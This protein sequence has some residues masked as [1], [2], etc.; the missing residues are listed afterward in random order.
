VGF[1]LDGYVLRPARI[2]PGNAQST[3]EVTV[4]VDRDHVDPTNFGYDLS[5]SRVVEPA[6][7]MYRA[8]VLNR[9][10]AEQEE[11]LIWPASTSSLSV[12]E[13]TAFTMTGVASAVVV[14]TGTLAVSD[15]SSPDPD[16]TD[17]TDRVYVQDSDGRAIGQVRFLSVTRGDGLGTIYMGPDAT[18]FTPNYPFFSQNP[19]IGEVVFTEAALTAL[20][21]GVSKERGD[22]ITMVTYYLGDSKFWWCRNDPHV[23][24]FGW[25]GGIQKWTPLKGAPPQNLGPLKEDGAYVLSPRLTRFTAGDWLPGWDGATADVYA[26]IRIGLYSNSSS[27][28]PDVVVVTDLVVEAPEDI[29]WAAYVSGTHPDGASAVVGV[30]N[31]VLVFNPDYLALH[32][33]KTVW[34][35]PESFTLAATGLMK[36]LSEFSLTS[37]SGHPI[38]SPIPSPTD[39]PMLRLGYRRYLTPIPYDDD[40]SLPAPDSLTE[41]SF[42]WSRTTGQ[43][44]LCA[45]DVGKAIPTNANYQ[46]SYLK[47]MVYYDGVSMTTQPVPARYPVAVVKENGNLLDG[48]DDDHDVPLTGDLY[49]RRAAPLPFPGTSGIRFI[50]DKTGDIPTLTSTGTAITTRPNGNGLV[51]SAIGKGDNFVFAS[52]FAFQ[53]LDNNEYE[54]DLSSFSFTVPKSKAEIARETAAVQPTGSTTASRME[55]RRRS[56]SGDPLYFSQAEITPSIYRDQASIYSRYGEPYVLTGNEVLRFTIDGDLTGYVWDASADPAV[57]SGGSF[58]AAVIATSL[59]QTIGATR[60]RVVR[61]RVVI[62]AADPTNGS[63]EIGWNLPLP[64]GP[65]IGDLSGHAALGF[66]PG[67]RVVA[68]DAGSS[69]YRWLPDNGSCLGLYRSPQNLGR[70][71]NTPDF[72]AE[73]RFDTQILTDSLAQTPFFYLPDLPLVDIPGFEPD[74]H[75][76]VRIG[77]EIVSLKDYDGVRYEF[78]DNR[79]TWL[80][81]NDTGAE[82][83]LTP[84]DTLQL[85][86]TGVLPQTI[87]SD[88]MASVGDGFGL[89]L[90]QVGIDA[91]TGF[92]Y[93]LTELTEGAEFLVPGGGAPGAAELIE[94]VGGQIGDGTAGVT[95]AASATFA[96]ANVVFVE[97]SASAGDLLYIISGD[98]EGVYT[99]SAVDS[100][101]NTLEVSPSFSFNS[102]GSGA[103]F[104]QWELY[105]GQT[106][107]VYDPA[108]VADVQQVEFNHLPNEPFIIRAL[109]PLGVIGVAATFI[110]FVETAL[111]NG[112]KTHVRL[113]LPATSPERTI[114][115]LTTG[116]EIGVVAAT[117]LSVP[118]TTNAHFL[119]GAFAI[120]VGSATYSV[121][122]GNLVA[123][124]TLAPLPVS[125]DVV[126][127]VSDSTDADFG[128]LQFGEDTLA[129]QAGGLVYFD[130][131]LDGPDDITVDTVQIDPASGQVQ[132][133]QADLTAYA[134]T[135]VYYVE[136][137]ITERSLDVQTSPMGG[138]FFF[139]KP[140]RENQI[141]EVSYF[142]A[143]TEG[144]KKTDSVTGD[145]LPMITE[146][147]ALTVR[148]EEATRVSGLVYSFNPTGRTLS[149][150]IEPFMW[151][152]VELQ[153][154]AGETTAS[155]DYDKSEITFTTEVVES[156]T[157]KINYGV[158]EAFGGETTYN[159]STPP[160]WRPPLLL[161]KEQTALVLG[162][163]RTE[164]VEVGA[165][166]RLGP[167]M[168]YIKAVSYSATSDETTV[169]LWPPQPTEAG[170]RSPGNDAPATISSVPVAITVDPSDPVYPS[171]SHAGFLMEITDAV[172][173]PIQKHAMRVVFEGD[174]RFFL[175][176]EHLLEIGGYPHFIIRS[177]LSEDG[178]Y[179]VVDLTAPVLQ[180][181]DPTGTSVRISARPLYGIEP[182]IFEGL[183]P[184]V[185]TE[186]NSVFLLGSRDAAGT[187]LPGRKLVVGA[188]YL[189]DGVNGTIRFKI[190]QKNGLQ[191][192]ERL[193]FCYTKRVVVQ[194]V[195]QESAI[196][197]PTYKAKYLHTTLPTLENGLLGSV[198]VGKYN[199]R[200]A[201][202]F[203][204]RTLPL[205]SYLTD[206]AE[207]ALKKVSQSSVSGGPMLAFPGSPILHKEGNLGLRSE[208]VDLYDQDRAAR[209]YIEFYNEAIVALEQVLETIDGRL[210]GDRDG[211]FRFFIGHG[212][213][214]YPPGYE[215][216]ITGNLNNRLIWRFIL[217]SWGP[218]L[219]TGYFKQKD[220]VVNPLTLVVDPTGEEPQ[221][222]DGEAANPVFLDFFINRQKYRVKNDMDDILLTGLKRP[223]ML[224]GLFPIPSTRGRYE[225]MWENHDFSRL[226]PER[227]KHFS[228]LF[229]GLESVVDPV[230]GGFSNPGY[231]SFGRKQEVPGP[232]PG[233]TQTTTARTIGRPI[234]QL[235]NP[236]LEELTR[237]T[238]VS[239][240]PRLARARIWE[241]HPKGYSGGS[242]STSGPTLV[243]TPLPF[244]EF[245]IDPTTGVPDAPLLISGGGA[246]ADLVSGDADQSTPGFVSGDRVAFGTPN[247][248]TF[249]LY[250]TADNT[251]V[252]VDEII[253]GFVITLKRASDN[254][255]ITSASRISTSLTGIAGEWEPV[256][257]DTIYVVPPVAFPTEGDIPG[258][259]DSPT[260]EQ[261]GQFSGSIPDY[262]MGFDVKARNKS[263]AIIDLSL[264]DD[265]D[266]FPLPLQS[267]LGQ[268]PPSPLS[269]IEGVAEFINTDEAPLQ[270]PCLKGEAADDSGEITIPYLRSAD[271]ELVVLK[272]VGA[273]AFSVLADAPLPT[274]NIPDFLQVPAIELQV[275]DPSYDFLSVYPDEI[276]GTDG[277]ITEFTATTVDQNPAT[278]YTAQDVRPVETAGT[279]TA[280]SGEGDL[281]R[282]DLLFVQAADQSDMP[283]VGGTGIQTVGDTAGHTGTGTAQSTIEIPRFISPTH[284]GH[285]H[286]YTVNN[287]YGHKGPLNTGVQVTETTLTV[288]V[289]GFQT[290]FSFTGI[291]LNDGNGTTFDEGGVAEILGVA[292][293]S[294]ASNNNAVI[295]NIYDPD[296]N[297]S[298]AAAWLG[299]VVITRA[300]ASPLTN[301]YVDVGGGVIP[302]PYWNTGVPTQVLAVIDTATTGTVVINTTSSVLLQLG[303]DPTAHY[304]YTISLDTY[305]DADTAAATGGAIV[306]PSGDG[307]ATAFIGRDRLTFSEAV[308]MEWALPR[309][310]H[311]GDGVGGDDLGMQLN[312]AVSPM[313]YIA[314]PPSYLSTINSATS[315]NGGTYLTFLERWSGGNEYVGT[316]TPATAPG[317]GDEVGTVRAMSWEGNDNAPLTG[318]A[319]GLIFS[320]A[321][322]SNLRDAA[323]YDIYTARGDFYDS[324]YTV[325]PLGIKPWITNLTTFNGNLARIESGDI[326]VVEGA[327][328][329]LIREETYGA[330]KTGTYLVRHAIPS[331]TTFAGSSGEVYSAYE[332]GVDD[333]EAEVSAGNKG[334]FDLR[335]PE[336]GSLDVTY[337]GS[338]NVTAMTLNLKNVPKALNLD[339][340][341]VFPL[342][343][344]QNI[345]RPF[346]G[347]GRVY[348]IFDAQYATYDSTIVVPAD[349][350]TVVPTSVYSIDFTSYTQVIGET[351][352]TMVL[353]VSAPA[354][355]AED[356]DVALEDF[357]PKIISGTT[358]SGMIRFMVGALQDEVTDYAGFPSNNVVGLDLTS[359]GDDAT[360]GFAYM[361][362]GNRLLRDSASLARPEP[363]LTFSPPAA[364]LPPITDPQPIR[365]GSTFNI[366]P[367]RAF[368]IKFRDPQTSQAFV[369]E[370]KRVLYGRFNTRNLTPT[371]SVHSGVPL[372]VSVGGFADQQWDYIHFTYDPTVPAYPPPTNRLQCLLPGDIWKAADSLGPTAL[373][374]VDGLVL[375]AGVFMEPSFPKPTTD[376]RMLGAP[377]PHV[378][379]ASHPLTGT[380]TD[381]LGTRSASDFSTYTDTWEP[382]SFYVRRIRRFH[383]AQATVTGYLEKLRY[384]YKIR[385]G[386]FDSYAVATRTFTAGIATY[387]AATNL[388]AF[389]VEE[390]NI[391]PGDTLR[392]FDTNGTLMDEAEIQ[393][394]DG[395]TTLILH[396]PGLTADLA[397][398]TSFEV[399]LRQPFVP[400]EQ[401]NE[402]L[403]D[404][405]T[406]EV[407]YS[408]SVTYPEAAVTP[409]DGGFVDGYPVDA[410]P[411][412]LQDPDISPTGT[413]DSWEAVGVQAN[414][415]LIVDPAGPLYDKKIE[416]GT[417]PI[418][419][420]SV[421]GR[422]PEHIVYPQAITDDNRGFYK[423]GEL[424]EDYPVIL[425]LSGA[426]IFAGNAQDG[427]DDIVF[428]M[429]GVSGGTPF[430]S[431]Y[432][433][434][435]TVHGS[436][437]TSATDSREGQQGLR[438][439]APPVDDGSG[440]L[441]YRE[442]TTDSPA[443]NLYRSVQPFGYKIIRPSTLFS[444][445]ATDT[446]LFM[447]ERLLSWME[448]IDGIYDKSGSYY[449]FQQEDQIDDLG[450]SLLPSSGLGLLTNRV[451]TSFRGL[452][453]YSPYANTDDCLSV[454]GRR[455]WILDFTLDS[456][457]PPAPATFAYTAFSTGTFGQ[458]PVLIGYINDILDNNDKLRELRYSWIAFRADRQDGSIVV[459]RRAK[460]RLPRNL[461]KQLELIEQ[462]KS[463]GS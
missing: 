209:A 126:N 198:L 71:N 433:V 269:A 94:V 374:T 75:F 183:F 448:E 42:A 335:F 122:N 146:F 340:P 226:Y 304:D 420:Q 416:M 162:G 105:T 314:G 27:D 458:R 92:P 391:N 300:S 207:V 38:L 217:D 254:A 419:D 415:Y 463:L 22:A 10:V 142:Q 298:G 59:N 6:A 316:F 243:A 52:S 267:W 394:V 344:S 138:A 50:P 36:E 284:R 145:P 410:T 49:V 407:V 402:Q 404:L 129:A 216:E 64:G 295:I 265:K 220:P 139:M 208:V 180:N 246:F 256:Q 125:G 303:L 359:A 66:L 152:G 375:L 382:V 18:T 320:S 60:V 355:D 15:P 275:I 388:G 158:L 46:L 273:S 358:I 392:V 231:Y 206:V 263:G 13:D 83:I 453:E 172:F 185:S 118:G 81:S 100:T 47:T 417:R 423:V 19:S 317:A 128:A 62:E 379:T 176:A 291:T 40:N 278:L 173:L 25:D 156:D 67:W 268:N 178:R 28:I 151:V 264:P 262:R 26:L 349:R 301:L 387:G 427:S 41:G 347:T 383:D 431:E 328:E 357:A 230:S 372:L 169:T 12:V 174:L 53:K 103:A 307:S 131:V 426:C 144:T 445:E 222:V 33:G 4:G 24:R 450:N 421:D 385:R 190:P 271:S 114:Q 362:I 313:G 266:D 422:T 210:I 318:G 34:H 261:S 255:G 205:S 68:P 315:M 248:Q 70:K 233:E 115:Y 11:Y 215:D 299:R 196:I 378:V 120:R 286:W 168:V 289:A 31:G 432:V 441:V 281:R 446:I 396:R 342:P 149:Q 232:N 111:K 437:L 191:P 187:L 429:E 3:G 219:G 106:Q 283:F 20:G 143:A 88:A 333:G 166:L 397:T 373:P 258:S 228:R 77:D 63:V 376:I 413:Y 204:Y 308:A 457:I 302:M 325:T 102:G 414:D 449:I 16:P 363:M 203:Y 167:L 157:V 311:P 287:L 161:E 136:Q 352:A 17:G 444:P 147:L 227:T 159:V 408:R 321:P 181:F 310:T 442:R 368:D 280:E 403:L 393:K 182:A 104:A 73:G 218:D 112:R 135:E 240:Q 164:D 165:V 312:V 82:R 425:P 108:L 253:D 390:V 327:D 272:N 326:V 57:S 9:P 55:I 350:Y 141:V 1:N 43:T 346:A 456:E 121:A 235:S 428:G 35:S 285:L 334:L 439:T 244:S 252:L 44:V 356:V 98:N 113:G 117:A 323:A 371:N 153:N 250:E 331:T 8:A 221:S 249:S 400:H 133:A 54:T 401:S 21:G 443:L 306:S 245:P 411:H 91:T 76:K 160:V 332:S 177:D 51:R 435:P 65:G 339:D 95:T 361:T 237:L 257:G 282:G 434:L 360:F 369:E 101:A 345:F 309:S 398:A 353:D 234:G 225:E 2:A 97:I 459:A 192:G 366:S 418:G 293:F 116:I 348:F 29:S 460:R 188:D 399:Y 239:I 290:T 343:P 370:K 288:P 236:A 409:V 130:E 292:G 171:G 86:A 195:V 89:Y 214:Y 276:L 127:Y 452:K 37:Y 5:V 395:T 440:T 154:Y 32:G 461:R 336:V 61:D 367:A 384:L 163:D 337:D 132:L 462:Q 380:Y 93:T 436:L 200:S 247:G 259:G 150:V 354:K 189:A 199:F 297:I 90:R 85:E 277:N 72:R 279:Y 438:P 229:P 202:S 319:S 338:G 148:L 377:Q 238:D 242:S 213:R 84:T 405:L 341:D 134:Q 364:T 223:K 140:L 123:V 69:V 365:S 137:M 45:N 124:S 186:T 224:L 119:S 39:R 270:L 406:E 424:D 381:V 78:D 175:G 412:G 107:D 260:M 294:V 330:T 7:D 212:K 110:A 193:V 179:T 170:S 197:S 322:S 454:L 87:S 386:D 79:L 30:A 329:N 96:D 430:N 296:P 201:D 109:A 56:V 211:K 194:P 184:F 99:V 305:I 14:P 74:V 58:S 251:F 23:T 389:D 241:Y 455:F 451:L 324:D 80:L 351:T 48:S 155:I 447:R 274:H